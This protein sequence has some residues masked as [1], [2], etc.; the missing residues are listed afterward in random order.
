MPIVLLTRADG[1]PAPRGG[2]GRTTLAAIAAEAGVRQP[3]AEMGRAAA[4]MLGELIENRPLPSR[5]L[6]L[7]TELIIRESAGP[8]R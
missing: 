5:R 2:T 8:V 7:S 1:D 3:L 6:E 4:Q